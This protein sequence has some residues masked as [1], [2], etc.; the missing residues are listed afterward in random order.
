MQKNPEDFL[1]WLAQAIFE[2]MLTEIEKEIA[3][4]NPPSNKPRP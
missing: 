4:D 1:E 2:N 3:N